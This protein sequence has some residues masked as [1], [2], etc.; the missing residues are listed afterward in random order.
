MQDIESTFQVGHSLRGRYTVIEVL[1]QGAS[2]AVYLVKDEQDSHKRFVLKEVKDTHRKERDSFCFD[3]AALKRLYHPSLPDIYKAFSDD[4]TDGFSILMEY[5]EG[6]SLEEVRQLMPGKRFSLHTALTLL[7]PVMDSTSY[8]HRQQPHLV[9]GD[10]K[11][12]I[13][14]ASLAGS[15]TPTKLVDFGGADNSFTDIPTQQSSLNYRATEQF[16]K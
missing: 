8:L 12:S 7:S 13:I 15:A 14:I 3:A 11:P 10:I 2:G 9:H 1:G 16:G 6:S 5:V 4:K